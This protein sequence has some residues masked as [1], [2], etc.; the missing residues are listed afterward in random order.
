MFFSALT[1]NQIVAAVLTFV[2]MIL[3]LACYFVRRR[4]TSG[5]ARRPARPG[6]ARVP[7]LWSESLGGQLPIRDVL[8]WVVAGRV[9]PVPVDQGAGNP[10][11]ELMRHWSL[12]LCHW[13]GDRIAV[14][15]AGAVANDQ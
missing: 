15:P 3:F 10:A 2:A 11:V 9:L 14:R 6:Q 13:W 4:A 1:S 12:V 5:W 8:L 7:H